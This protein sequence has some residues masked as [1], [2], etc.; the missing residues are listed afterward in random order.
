MV[1]LVPHISIVGENFSP[2]LIEKKGIIQFNQKNEKGD[3]AKVGRYK[4]TALPY[5]SATIVPPADVVG[6]DDKIIWLIQNI[7]KHINEINLIVDIDIC[8][9]IDVFYKHQCNLVFEPKIL[10]MLSELHIPLTISC[11]EE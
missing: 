4:G 9:H 2:M 10:S 7:K 6:V 5:G 8:L 3:I 1:N 11:W